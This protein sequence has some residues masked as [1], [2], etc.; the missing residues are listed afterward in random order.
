MIT[1]F[2][3]KGDADSKQAWRILDSLLSSVPVIGNILSFSL[4]GDEGSLQL[5]YIHHIATLTI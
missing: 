3:L 2:L 5:V 1:G 4:L